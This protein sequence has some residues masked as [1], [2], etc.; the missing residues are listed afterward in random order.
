ML[1]RL[2]DNHRQLFATVYPNKMNPVHMHV[3]AVQHKAPLV[4]KSRVALHQKSVFP[5]YCIHTKFGNYNENSNVQS[6]LISPDPIE[7]E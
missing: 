1:C 2:N 5:Y 6:L 4:H 7:C 3:Y